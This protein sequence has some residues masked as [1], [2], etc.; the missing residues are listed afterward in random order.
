MKSD[1]SSVEKHLDTVRTGH[2]TKQRSIP[3]FIIPSDTYKL[4]QMPGAGDSPFD[5]VPWRKYDDG[6]QYDFTRLYS[7]DALSSP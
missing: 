5:W 7:T 2:A 3:Y 6:A 4:T 1:E